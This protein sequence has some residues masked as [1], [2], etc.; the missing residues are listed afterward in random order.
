MKPTILY[1][2]GIILSDIQFFPLNISRYI[3]CTCMLVQSGAI[4]TLLYV[5]AYVQE[6]I[7]SLNHVDYLPVHIHRPYNNLHLY[8][9]YLLKYYNSL[10]TVKSKIFAIIL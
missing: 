2:K 10:Y 8:L 9:V 4:R 1:K 5:C 6:I 3:K 7:H